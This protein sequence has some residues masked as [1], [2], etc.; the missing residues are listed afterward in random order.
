[1][2]VIKAREAWPA[3]DE[4]ELDGEEAVR[5]AFAAGWNAARG[6][7]YGTTSGN[8]SHDKAKRPGE[9]QV[10]IWGRTK[11][12]RKIALVMSEAD[13]VALRDNLTRM[14]VGL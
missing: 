11:K 8:V 2:N 13:A 3:Q 10:T 6:T 4:P 1:M 14:G 9:L 12:G 7:I 5:N